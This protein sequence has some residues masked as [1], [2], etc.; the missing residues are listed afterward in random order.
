MGDMKVFTEIYERNAGY[1]TEGKLESI[2]GS[3][4]SFDQTLKLRQELPRLFFAHNVRSILD[5][6]CGDWNWMRRINLSG[7]E[8]HGADIVPDLV[9]RNIKKFGHYF[10]VLDITKDDLPKVDLVIVRYCFVH[11]SYEDVHKALANIKRSGSKYLLTT[12]FVDRPRNIDIP[13]GYWRAL[14]LMVKPFD[15]G[16]PVEIINEGCTEEGNQ[17]T[18]KSM[19]LWNI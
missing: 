14:N 13:T 11:F 9:Q 18:D 17:Y 3:G 10:K 8:Y 15:M 1:Q 6:P 16:A 19:V 4:S 5:I 2:S 12:S 7:I